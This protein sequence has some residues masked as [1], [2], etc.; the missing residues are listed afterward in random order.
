MQTNRAQLAQVDFVQ[1]GAEL[2]KALEAEGFN[3]ESFSAGFAL[4]D[5]LKSVS[6]PAAPLPHWRDRLPKTS[7]WWF[8]IDRYFSRDPLLTT[9]FVTS[10]APIV[11]HEAYQTLSRSFQ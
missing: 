1:T 9:G 5:E 6:N 11:S 7:S 3:R 4:L 8:L 10:N 2:E